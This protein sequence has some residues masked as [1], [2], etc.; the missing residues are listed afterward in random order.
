MPEC[1]WLKFASII[2][3]GYTN[4]VLNPYDCLEKVRH[5]ECVIVFISEGKARQFWNPINI[6]S[7]NKLLFSCCILAK[8]HWQ[9]LK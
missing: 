5:H 1:S 2:N 8:K 3:I 6:L 9:I 7:G 4:T